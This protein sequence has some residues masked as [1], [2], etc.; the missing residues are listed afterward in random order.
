[1]ATV[2][3]GRGLIYDEGADRE[4][5]YIMHMWIWRYIVGSG[6]D[7]TWNRSNLKFYLVLKNI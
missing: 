2:K 6:L 7:I 5:F 1:M 3:A 4:K